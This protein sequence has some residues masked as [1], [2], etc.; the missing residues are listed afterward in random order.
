MKSKLG[1]CLTLVA[2]ILILTLTLLMRDENTS[3][4]LTTDKAEPAKEN[5]SVSTTE[6]MFVESLTKFLV[7]KINK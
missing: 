3:V 5:L 6:F 2:V 7:F 4:T 1:Y